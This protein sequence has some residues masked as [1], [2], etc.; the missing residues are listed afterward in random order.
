MAGLGIGGSAIAPRRMAGRRAFW[1]IV[2]GLV[3]GAL[4]TRVVVLFM[5]ESATRTLLTTSASASLGP[6]GVDVGA[7]ALVLG[8]L[9]LNVN[10]LSLVGV[11]GAALVARSWLY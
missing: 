10:L 7:I 1:V 6:L 2:A 8:P 5:P 3:V 11:L 9:T 4:L